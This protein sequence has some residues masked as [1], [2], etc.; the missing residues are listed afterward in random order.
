MADLHALQLTQLGR[1]GVDQLGPLQQQHAP[2]RRIGVAPARERLL[3]GG[4]RQVHVGAAATRSAAEHLAGGRVDHIDGLAA[5]GRHPVAADQ[6]CV[7]DDQ[8]AR[9]RRRGDGHGSS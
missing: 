1:A 7:I 8:R 5:D 9:R 2:G 4:H 3:R 6:L